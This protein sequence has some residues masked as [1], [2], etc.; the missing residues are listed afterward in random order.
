MSTPSQRK[1]TTAVYA[2]VVIV[3]AIAAFVSWASFRPRALESVKEITVYVR[4]TDYY[5]E[6][7]AE[8]PAD[9]DEATPAEA[10]ADGKAGK[11]AEDDDPSL[12]TLTFETTARYL[13][14]ALEPSGVL[15]Y[16]VPEESE[17]VEDDE[18]SEET[19]EAETDRLILAAD[20]EYAA[21][22]M[23]YYWAFTVNSEEPE[24][25]VDDQPI[26][27]GDVYYFYITSDITSDES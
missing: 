14:E 22:S 26:A 9:E 24:Y 20:G 4:H 19:E 5:L 7:I 15:E 25:T 2:A 17:A 8:V 16:W 21:W 27:D 11:D 23:G 13:D 18:E 1:K 12:F 6:S 10:E 3:L